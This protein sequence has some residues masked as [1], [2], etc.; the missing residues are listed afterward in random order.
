MKELVFNANPDMDVP[1]EALPY[2]PRAVD[3]MS[4][5]LVKGNG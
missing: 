5:I 3:S 1:A 2:T 4:V